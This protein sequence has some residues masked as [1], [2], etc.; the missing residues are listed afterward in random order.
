M[1]EFHATVGIYR[2]FIRVDD[3]FKVE[4]RCNAASP[5]DSA[6]LVLKVYPI[7]DGEAWDE[8]CDVFTVDEAGIIELE[9]QAR[10]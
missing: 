1:T 5:P 9:T 2:A 6:Q 3:R 8:P 4:V 10:E 7:T